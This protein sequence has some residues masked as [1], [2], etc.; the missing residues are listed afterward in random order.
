MHLAK[1][2]N[3]TQPK[4]WN[5][6]PKKTHWKNEGAKK[7][8]EKMQARGKTCFLCNTRNNTTHPK[9]RK[10]EPKIQPQMKH[11][12][13][14]NAPRNNPA[15]RD[16]DTRLLPPHPYRR[17]HHQPLARPRSKNGQWKPQT[18]YPE[19]A[20]CNHAAWM[21]TRTPKYWKRSTKSHFEAVGMTYDEGRKPENVPWTEMP[22][23]NGNARQN[24]RMQVVSH[25]A[26]IGLR[27]CKGLVVVPADMGGG[28]VIE[29]H[30]QH[31]HIM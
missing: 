12:N 11:T 14:T 31:I 15:P 26:A 28:A 2:T 17:Y 22:A 3:F 16:D 24:N 4:V 30:H 23:P 13:T 21:K 9:L 20:K 7:S 8:V 1:T 18:P 5:T 27:P 19:H 29:Y 6:N 25:K 10:H